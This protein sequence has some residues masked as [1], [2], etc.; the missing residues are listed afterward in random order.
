MASHRFTAAAL[1]GQT[2]SAAGGNPTHVSK[3][4]SV[5]P[6]DSAWETRVQSNSGREPSDSHH[7]GKAEKRIGSIQ[8][9]ICGTR[10]PSQN[11]PIGIT[12]LAN[13][14]ARWR[15]FFVSVRAVSRAWR[16]IAVLGRRSSCERSVA[17]SGVRFGSKCTQIVRQERR[18]S[19]CRCWVYPLSAAKSR[20][21]LAFF[22]G[23]GCTCRFLAERAFFLHHGS[24]SRCKWSGRS[25]ARWY[26]PEFRTLKKSIFSVGQ[27]NR[28]REAVS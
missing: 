27:I 15:E 21:G 16:E 3:K 20:H 9:P 1:A 12:T 6:L 8:H 18:A 28:D 22:R 7:R 10:A 25:T 24:D 13:W 2:L 5:Y 14:S 11:E 17:S 23:A 26:Q 19:E 4:A